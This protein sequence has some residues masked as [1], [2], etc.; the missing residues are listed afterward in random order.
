M[1][2]TEY[3]DG[4][5]MILGLHGRLD[6]ASSPDVDG[7]L[8][9]YVDGAR[10][11]VFDLTAVEYISSLGLRVLL[12]AAKQA[13]QM[14]QKLVLAGLGSAV[15]EVFDISGFTGLFVI[16]PDRATAVDSLR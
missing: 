13:Q 11:L 14:Q 15:R 6:A 8:I 7:R 5:V 4:N 9:A 12:K 3:H 16:Y 10:P 1:L 2:V